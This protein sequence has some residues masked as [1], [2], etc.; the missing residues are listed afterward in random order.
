MD[1]FGNLNVDGLQKQ[2]QP[3][4]QVAIQNNPPKNDAFFDFGFD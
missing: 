2:P 4:Q 3:S 1:L